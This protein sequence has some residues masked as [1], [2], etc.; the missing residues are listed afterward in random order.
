MRNRFSDWWISDNTKEKLDDENEELSAIELAQAKRSIADFVRIMT[1]RS[2]PVEYR[3]EEG[4]SYT[5]GEK[6]VI[7]AD[8]VG[9]EGFDA[10]VGVALHESSHIC[11]TDFDMLDEFQEA[12]ENG[13][14]PDFVPQDIIDGIEPLL[15][16]SDKYKEIEE[17]LKK[18]DPDY[19]ETELD[20]ENQA[21]RALHHIWNVVEDRWIDQC[22]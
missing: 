8:V 18:A 22:A 1:K 5:D 10:T 12:D 14:A 13:T 20:P 15:K 2:I 19:D 6:V 4:Q 3:E 9:D 7:G 17:K 16:K 11:K 21:T